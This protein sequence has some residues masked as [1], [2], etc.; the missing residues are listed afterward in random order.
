MRRAPGRMWVVV[1][2]AAVVLGH[3]GPA[4]AGARDEV[5]QVAQEWVQAWH[6]GNVDGITAMYADDAQYFSSLSVFRVDGRPAIQGTWTGLFAAFPGRRLALRHESFQAYGDA[7]G[8]WSAYYQ[9]TV[10]DRTGKVTTL[11]G[12]FSATWAKQGGRWMIV[13]HHF[14][15]LPPVS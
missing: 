7:V 9:A 11:M 6:A 12:R 15:S 4:G 13:H 2:V 5:A 14:S 1:L 8:V 3:L 10:T